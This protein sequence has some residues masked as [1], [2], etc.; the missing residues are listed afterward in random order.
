MCYTINSTLKKSFKQ[1]QQQTRNETSLEFTELHAGIVIK[2]IL[3]KIKDQLR[4]DIREHEAHFRFGKVPVLVQ[5]SSTLSIFI[6]VA[7]LFKII[8]HDLL[9]F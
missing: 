2:F 5:I 8:R 9:N 4:L 6:V 7:S 1:S 3:N